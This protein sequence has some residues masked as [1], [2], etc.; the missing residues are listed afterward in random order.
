MDINREFQE[1]VDIL[2]DY[3]K[4][5]VIEDIVECC[6]RELVELCNEKK[7]IIRGGGIHSELLLNHRFLNQDTIYLRVLVLIRILQ[8]QKYSFS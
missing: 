1:A 6:I 3:G 7:V 5:N 4:S 8:F 2:G